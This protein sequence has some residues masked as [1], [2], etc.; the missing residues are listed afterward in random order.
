MVASVLVVEDYADLRSVIANA[1]AKGDYSCEA[2]SNPDDAIGRLKRHQFSAILLAPK[3]PLDQDPVMQ[4]LM[5]TQPGELH[6]VIL[7]L[8]EAEADYPTLV[9][10]FG[11]AQLLAKVAST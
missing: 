2:A 8:D 9:K 7:M 11:K 10:P 6:K 1:L 4:F 3:F 5:Q